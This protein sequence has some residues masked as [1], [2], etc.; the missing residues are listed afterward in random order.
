MSE[1]LKGWRWPTLALLASAGMLAAAHGFEILGK[2][3]P[4]PLCLRQRDVYWAALAMSATGLILWNMRSTARFLSALDLMLGLV[5]LTS[6]VVAG[7]HAGVEWG[8]WEGPTGCSATPDPDTIVGMDLG[9]SLD[10]PVATAACEDAPWRMLG[11]SMAGWNALVSAGLA[12]LSFS[13]SAYAARRP[14]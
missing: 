3:D 2:L 6:A 4:C 5:F 11:L 8:W 13:A 1:G 9:G 14:A 12:V 7:Y 10:Q